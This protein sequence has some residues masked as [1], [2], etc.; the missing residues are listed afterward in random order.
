MWWSR[1]FKVI[2]PRSVLRVPFPCLTLLCVAGMDEDPT[3]L[4]SG[5]RLFQMPSPAAYGYAPEHWPAGSCMCACRVI[6]TR[7]KRE[8]GRERQIDREGDKERERERERDGLH[9]SEGR[10]RVCMPEMLRVSGTQTQ[11]SEPDFSERPSR[12]VGHRSI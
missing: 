1:T 9:T 12:P 7:R 11:S 8:R 6:R 2:Q 10:G 3:T 5:G 4:A